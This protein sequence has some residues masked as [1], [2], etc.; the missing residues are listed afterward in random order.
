M[1]REA[2]AEG[3]STRTQVLDYIGEKFRVKVNLP[4]WKSSADITQ[5]LLKYVVLAFKTYFS[6]Y[7]I[8]LGYDYYYCYFC[9]PFLVLFL[10]SV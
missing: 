1:L 8:L 3:L 2:L 7:C 5:F 10:W 6:Q 9:G 4:P